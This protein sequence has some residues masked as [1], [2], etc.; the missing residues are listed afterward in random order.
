M[1]QNKTFKDIL[2]FVLLWEASNLAEGQLLC[3]KTETKTKSLVVRQ[4]MQ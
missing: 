1:K 4:V 3:A 2:K